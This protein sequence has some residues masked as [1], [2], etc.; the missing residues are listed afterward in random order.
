MYLLKQLFQFI[1]FKSKFKTRQV[2]DVNTM[3]KDKEIKKYRN[4]IIAC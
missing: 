1:S 2:T 4:N 3:K